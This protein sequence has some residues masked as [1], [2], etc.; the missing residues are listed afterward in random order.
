MNK[1][2]TEKGLSKKSKTNRNKTAKKIEKQ[3][4]LTEI[5]LPNQNSKQEPPR[6]DY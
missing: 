6:L 2:L 3:K 5:S 4:P 1:V